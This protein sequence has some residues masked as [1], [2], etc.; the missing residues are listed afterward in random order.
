[1]EPPAATAARGRR[2]FLVLAIAV[3]AVCVR[4]GFWQLDRLAERRARNAAIHAQLER[5][6]LRLPEDLDLATDLAYRRATARGVFD[7]AGEIYLTSR[8]REG[9]AGVHVVTP[10][11]L[12]DGGP[13]LLVDRGW[14]A[15]TVYRAGSSDGW[16]WPGAVE[17]EGTLLPS[18]SEPSLAFF[19]D[20]LPGPGDLPLK[21]WRALYIPGIGSQLAYPVL[22]VYLAQDSPPPEASMP[23]PEPELDLSDGP[24]LGY[25][26]QW[27]SF[28][29]IAIGGAIVWARRR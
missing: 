7:P 19:A 16:A 25:A 10:L 6:P 26:I 18:Q 2:L 13:A 12:A 24:H 23:Q 9:I 29:A 15:D 20:R 17:V 5:P 1:M 14:L 27:F 21:N 28:A 4:L 22:D 8:S 3:G 11:I